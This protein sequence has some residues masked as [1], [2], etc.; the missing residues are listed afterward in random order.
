LVYSPRGSL[1]QHEQ[2][3]SLFRHPTTAE[4]EYAQQAKNDQSKAYNYF[5]NGTYR[6]SQPQP[7]SRIDTMILGQA[8]FLSWFNSSSES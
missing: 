8:E 5:M 2:F 4:I 3:T 1:L 7:A 6:D